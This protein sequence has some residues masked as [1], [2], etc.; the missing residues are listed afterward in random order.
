MTTCAAVRPG[1]LSEA[2]MQNQL[3]T[4]PAYGHSATA[5]SAQY[6]QIA[7]QL[8]GGQVSALMTNSTSTGRFAG[9]KLSCPPTASTGTV[10]LEPNS[11]SLAWRNPQAIENIV[12]VEG[13]IELRFG[14]HLEHATILKRFDM[15]SVP[16]NVRHQWRN[17]SSQVS[18]L[19]SILSIA[20]GESYAAAFGV[21][22]PIEA[23]AA[24]ARGVAQDEQLGDDITPAELSLRTTRFEALVPYKKDLN[25][26]GGLPPEATMSLSAGS[27]Y[28]LIVPEGHIGRSRTAPMYGNQGLYISI[29]ECQAG[30]DGPPPHSHSDTQESFYVLNG[31]FDISTGFDNEQTVVAK[32]HDL[33]SVPNDVMRT[34]CNTHTEP[35]RLLVIIQG[36]DRMKDTVSFS[37]RIGEDFVKRFGPDIISKYEEIRMTFDAE[38]RLKA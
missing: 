33:F 12:C 8:W 29:A 4:S 30:N 6:A 11:Q 16:K 38:D 1:A 20:P 22:T 19:L 28:P 7:K 34:F 10:I 24:N 27:V 25:R 14:P 2:Q 23:T 31:S 32:P 35:S 9:A 37:K 17:A 13:E 36:P 15:V 3:S 26:T 5:P 18:R 21:D